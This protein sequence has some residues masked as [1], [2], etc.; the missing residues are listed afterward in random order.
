MH[1]DGGGDDDRVLIEVMITMSRAFSGKRFP[2]VC[3][4]LW[5]D[6]NACHRGDDE[7][8]DESLR[9]QF[10]SLRLLG[11]IFDCNIYVS[12]I[13]AFHGD[14]P[15]ACIYTRGGG[16]ECAVP[17]AVSRRALWSQLLQCDLADITELTRIKSLQSRYRAHYISYVLLMTTIA[18]HCNST[19]IMSSKCA[20]DVAV[21]SMAMMSMGDSMRS[22]AMADYC[23]N[24]IDDVMMT[25]PL[26]SLSCKELQLYFYLKC[27]NMQQIPQYIYEVLEAPAHK[28]TRDLVRTI[29]HEST[30]PTILRTFEK[31]CPT[32]GMTS[33]P[34]PGASGHNNKK[35]RSN[36][37]AP[38]VRC[39]V[40]RM[41]M[42]E[43]EMTS[44]SLFYD[45]KSIVI[46]SS[47]TCY[48]CNSMLTNNDDRQAVFRWLN[49]IDVNAM[50]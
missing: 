25:Q 9:A 10:S 1:G 46:S 13:E 2:L 34:A 39:R 20:D 21:D 45:A 27:K 41:P 5:I 24:L 11:K 30:V 43:S 6:I 37:R 7:G 29:P 16:G 49:L 40:C 44:S 18:R 12:C 17:D 3:S 31:L 19:I 48:L 33:P 22:P 23:Y 26:R 38:C 8:G 35:A 42:A 36:D 50:E 4:V 14:K 28:F 15:Y 47:H 32:P